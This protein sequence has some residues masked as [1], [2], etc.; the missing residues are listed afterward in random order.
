MLCC[1]KSSKHDTHVFLSFTG[2]KLNRQYA[3]LIQYFAF[4]ELGGKIGQS[5]RVLKVKIIMGSDEL[6]SQYSPKRCGCPDFSS[7]LAEV[8]MACTPSCIHQPNGQE[9]TQPNNLKMEM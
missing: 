4:R 8:Y 9:R 7:N 2:S 5:G 6:G 3:H 1:K